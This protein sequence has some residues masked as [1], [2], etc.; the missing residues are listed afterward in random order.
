MANWQAKFC[1]CP[2]FSN[3]D[4]N[5]IVCEGLCEGNT[6]NLVYENQADRRQ[7]MKIRCESIEGCRK[8]PIYGVLDRKWG[9][10]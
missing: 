9:D 7:Y 4:A 6:I 10:R 5:R 2:F 1:K 3:Y 8:C